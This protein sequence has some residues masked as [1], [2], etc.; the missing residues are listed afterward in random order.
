ML[1]EL[2]LSSLKTTNSSRFLSLGSSTGMGLLA[3]LENK[4]VQTIAMKLIHK[5]RTGGGITDMLMA[6]AGIQNT[7]EALTEGANFSD[8]STGI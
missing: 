7:H 1:L 3:M 2:D 4:F 5:M 8:K 6:I